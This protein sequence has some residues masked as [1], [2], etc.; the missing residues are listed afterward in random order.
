MGMLHRDGKL[1]VQEHQKPESIMD[2]DT[3]KEGVENMDKLETVYSCKRRTICW[4]LVILFNISAYNA[5]VIWTALNPHR[6]TKEIRGFS[7]RSWERQRRQ[8]IPRAPA[9]VVTVRIQ[10]EATGATS[11]QPA[12]QTSADPEVRVRR[13]CMWCV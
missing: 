4:S 1:S 3:T 11:V 9:S 2:C 5:A 10:R 12:E 7:S 13:C 8:D 6:N